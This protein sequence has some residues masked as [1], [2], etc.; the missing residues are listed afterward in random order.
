VHQVY[1]AGPPKL[2]ALFPR[3]LTFVFYFKTWSNSITVLTGRLYEP[4]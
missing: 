3:K 4:D 1:N 2:L